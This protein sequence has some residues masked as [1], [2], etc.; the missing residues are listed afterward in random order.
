MFKSLK[1][2]CLFI[3]LRFIEENIGWTL[4]EIAYRLFQFIIYIFLLPITLILRILGFRCLSINT[5]RIG[6]LAGEIDCFIKM[7][8]LGLIN[9]NYRYFIY[10]DSGVANRVFLD[11]VSNKITSITTP[12]VSLI[13]KYLCFGPGIKYSV[14]NYLLAINGAAKYYDVC[15]LW[16]DRP[17][18]FSL[19][20]EHVLHGLGVLS[21]LG[22]PADSSYVCVHVRSQGFILSDDM[23]HAH[24]NF[25]VDSL[26]KAIQEIVERGHF[27]ILMGDSSSQ[28]ISPRRMVIDY[29]HSVYK[30]DMMDVF[31]CASAKFFLGNSSG[32]F[33]MSSVFGTPCA[34]SNMLPFVCTGFTKKD[35]SIPKLLKCTKTGKYLKYSKI[36]ESGVAN[37]RNAKQ[38]ELAE[39]AVIQNT[40]SDISD[41][42][43]DMLAFLDQKITSDVLAR[44][45]EFF[46]KML[47]PESYSFKTAS[48]LS[49]RFV[50]K[51]REIFYD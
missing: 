45:S 48:Y 15:S 46:L 25:T 1:I 47:Q 6:H 2:R 33:I 23:V 14:S 18:C 31:L 9:P 38:Y 41:L 13:L 17:P 24:R 35:I 19:N 51:N 7:Q 43:Q 44:K 27:C 22:L 37:Y 10:S 12:A 28:R 39:I 5:R 40:E 49:P 20:E 30:S 34:L 42:V 50:E 36:L 8:S 32:L 29:A 11:Y 26:D 21:D 3:Y 16:G 4:R